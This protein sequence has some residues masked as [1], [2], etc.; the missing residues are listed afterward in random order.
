MNLSLELYTNV[1][2]ILLCVCAVCIIGLF[3]LMFKSQKAKNENRFLMQSVD[4]LQHQI[5]LLLAD[6]QFLESE[7]KTCRQQLETKSQ[8]LM[9]QSASW[10]SE[11]LTFTHQIAQ[12]DKQLAENR[13][14]IKT[15]EQRWQDFEH[16]TQE[17]LQFFQ[18]NEIRITNQ[19]ESLAKKIVQ[20][21]QTE[22]ATQSAQ[23]L[24]HI[25]GPLKE[26]INQFRQQLN[27]GLSSEAKERHTLKHEIVQ[28]QS[29]NQQL[30]KEAINLTK[31]LKS[32]NK[33]QGN[34]GE[35]ILTKLLE[36]VGFQ[37][38]RE[39]NT[40][41]SFIDEDNNRW[42][43][44]VIIN[45]PEGRQV[46][47]DAKVSLVAYERYHSAENEIQMQ[48]A[49][50]ELIL[51]IRQHMKGLSQKHYSALSGINTLDYVLMFIPIEPA[52]M[53]AINAEENLLSESQKQNI[54]LVSP[55]T[56]LAAL[57]TIQQLWRSEY[58]NQNATLIAQRASKLYDKFRLF[59]DDLLAI[60]Q[61]LNKTE[62]SYQAAINKLTSGRGNIIKQVESFRELG[63]DV[64]KNITD[65]WLQD[66]DG[67]TES[68]DDESIDDLNL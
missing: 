53:I 64:K 29:L 25:V 1:V 35:M 42:M 30:A 32:D 62:Q 36:A 47:I 8:Q 38:G 67:Y 39:F 57:R 27:E 23:G 43:P 16:N 13:F 20:A 3:W 10:H 12:Y 34:W 48:I 41:C 4:G 28:L 63:V 56:L 45:L 11:R 6:K 40:Q 31:A 52:F 33:I 2:V 26:Q 21:S 9:E 44:D 5:D 59:L 54:I 17:R 49:T 58:K 18:E 65:N 15:L 66:K 7:L 55:S 50:N 37:E 19:F 14:E 22:L 60:G 51:S 46:I 24:L 61:Q 68:E